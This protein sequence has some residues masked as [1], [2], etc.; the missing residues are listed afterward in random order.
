M[1]DNPYKSPDAEGERYVIPAGSAIHISIW[2]FP[3]LPKT[4]HTTK[5]ELEFGA[6]FYSDDREF[7]FH[8]SYGYLFHV[9]RKY[10]RIE[11][12]KLAPH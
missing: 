9:P 12:Q 6:V 10:V 11:K 4:A 5:S 3:R 7:T 8:Q 1:P 2:T